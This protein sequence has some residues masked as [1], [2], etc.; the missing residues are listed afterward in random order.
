[1]NIC[2]YHLTLFTD[3]YPPHWSKAYIVFATFKMMMSQA[4]GEMQDIPPPLSSS[5]PWL[6]HNLDD[7]IL[8]PLCLSVAPSITLCRVSLYLSVFPLSLL[9][10]HV[11]HAIY[12]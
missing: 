1:M 11:P 12:F 10:K 3:L 9:F 4:A 7:F 8:I 2:K 5:P 6:P